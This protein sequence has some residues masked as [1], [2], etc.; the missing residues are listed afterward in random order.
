MSR[1]SPPPSYAAA[2]SNDAT[3]PEYQD[4]DERTPNFLYFH[5]TS[6]GIRIFS[7]TNEK[8][9]RYY[10]G[11]YQGLDHP[12][13]ILHRGSDRSR[14]AAGQASFSH[15]EKDFVIAIDS[16]ANSLTAN[17]EAV[18]C[19]SSHSIFGADSYQYTVLAD[20]S[21]GDSNAAVRSLTWKHTHDSHLGSGPWKSKNFKLVDDATEQVIAVYINLS[22]TNNVMSRLEW[23]ISC[24]VDE[25]IR[26]LTVLMAFIERIRRFKKQASRASVVG[27]A[28]GPRRGKVY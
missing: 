5:R 11:R 7:A 1:N 23:K 28:Q 21:P 19:I 17:Q 25:E 3:I 27:A 14:P 18:R 24:S 2:T 8:E 22:D 9:P 20:T 13:V 4:I 12:D 15:T 26:A 16:P 6:Q 10:V